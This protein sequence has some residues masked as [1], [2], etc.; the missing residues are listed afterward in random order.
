MYHSYAKFLEEVRNNT[1][2]A[3][4]CYAEAEKIEEAA[5]EEAELEGAGGGARAFGSSDLDEAN[6]AVCVIDQKGIILTVNPC[7]VHNFGA[8]RRFSLE[9]L[10]PLQR[11]PSRIVQR[12]AA[13]TSR[14]RADSP[15]ARAVA[16]GLVA[17]YTSPN[18]LKGK[19][20]LG[21]VSAGSGISF[22]YRSLAALP[23]WSSIA[24]HSASVSLRSLGSACLPAPIP[25]CAS[26]RTS[27]S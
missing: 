16:R 8:L 26:E 21:L 9:S 15:P 12:A 14:G 5:A 3:Q 25:P 17:G 4:M 27:T 20:R 10:G 24:L 23:A 2:K 13:R 11:R 22:P 18:D 19:A 1:A 6:D 7:L